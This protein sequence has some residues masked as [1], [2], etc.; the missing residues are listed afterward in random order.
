[1]ALR[2]MPRASSAPGAL[3]TGITY[4]FGTTPRE[5]RASKG[6]PGGAA[7]TQHWA[8]A[9][10]VCDATQVFLIEPTA[11]P[12]PMLEVLLI[13]TRALQEPSSNQ[14]RSRSRA[15]PMRRAREKTSSSPNPTLR[16]RAELATFRVLFCSG[17]HRRN[18][19]LDRK[20]GKQGPRLELR[21]PQKTGLGCSSLELP[22]PEH[23][24]ENTLTPNDTVWPSSPSS[25][26]A[27][28]RDHL[29]FAPFW[30]AAGASGRPP[31]SAAGSRSARNPPQRLRNPK[32]A[33]W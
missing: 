14:P 23:P 26:G 28:R 27:P 19:D 4:I 10:N 30:Q 16:P 2:N 15:H 1:M 13:A 21:I 31:R 5:R 20:T 11:S 8:G 17:R 6:A 12:W 9:Q 32:E 22:A 3:G 7:A 18:R 24:G 29:S 25:G 33:G